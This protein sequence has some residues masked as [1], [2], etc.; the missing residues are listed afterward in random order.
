MRS[1]IL[2]TDIGSDVDDLF[3]L[4]FLAHAPELRL[5]GV[6]TVYGDTLL[7]ARIAAAAWRLTGNPQLPVVP[8]AVE[9]LSGRKISW[10]GHEGEGIPSLESASIDQSRT[11]EDFLIE[12]SKLHTGELE[13]LAIG[14]LTNIAKAITADAV[15][16]SRLK[17]LY[18]MGGAYWLDFSEHNIECDT[19]AAR[20]VFDSKI[21]II[22]IGLD[23]T[24]RVSL[25]E[26]Q[27]RFIRQLPDGLGTLLENQTRRWWKHLGQNYNYLHDPTAALAIV[28]PDLFLFKS[29]RVRIRMEEPLAGTVERIDDEEGN[30]QAAYDLSVN[31]VETTLLRYFLGGTFLRYPI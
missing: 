17:R 5:I 15:F 9:P 19:T 10:F 29:C 16:P 7:R 4:T 3:A 1:L 14:P 12:K 31:T 27:L 6:T 23:V 18:L 2:D 30:V 21:P 11:A 25:S 22:A 24:L 26:K 20:I 8:G 28:R 13:V